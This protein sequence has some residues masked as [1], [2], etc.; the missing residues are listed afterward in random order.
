MS[1]RE[2]LAAP[3]FSVTDGYYVAWTRRTSGAVS[4]AVEN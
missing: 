2:I 1:A 3:R 4:S